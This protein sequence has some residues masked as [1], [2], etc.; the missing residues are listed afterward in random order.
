M[1][2]LIF[3]YPD[4]S[5]TISRRAHV[6]VVASGDMEVLLEPS[7]SGGARVTVTTSVDG[8]RK[9]WKAM[10]DRFFSHYRG[11]AAIEIHDFG[12]TPG[13]VLLRLEQAVEQSNP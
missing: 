7:T 3:N 5:E 4:A 2:K 10:L 8:Y 11:A 13:T 1:E 12:A 6:G 9:T